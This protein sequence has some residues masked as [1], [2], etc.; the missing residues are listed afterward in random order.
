MHS[1]VDGGLERSW[2]GRGGKGRE[3]AEGQVDVLWKA[4]GHSL[5]SLEGEGTVVSLWGDPVY[6]PSKVSA[7][8]VA[9]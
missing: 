7:P 2:R 5:G 9:I 1:G 3:G 4:R 8:E 6:S